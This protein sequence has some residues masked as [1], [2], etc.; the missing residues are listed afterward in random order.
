[1]R[2]Q[3]HSQVPTPLHTLLFLLQEAAGI[4]IHPCKGGSEV[5]NEKPCM[6]ASRERAGSIIS[7]LLVDW[8][9]SAIRHCFL[10]ILPADFKY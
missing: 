10:H 4:V 1:M 3:C 8:N 9:C 7:L 5:P 2:A 6:S